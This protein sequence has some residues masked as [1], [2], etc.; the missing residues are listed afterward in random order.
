MNLEGILTEITGAADLAALDALRVST[1]GK[2]GS[3]SE[4]LKTLGGMS[5]EERKTQGAVIN[6]A[7]EAVTSAIK[8]RQAVLEE[9]AMAVQLQREAAD[10][11]LPVLP[12]PVGVLHPIMET[13]SVIRNYF[14]RQGFALGTGQD[15]EDVAHNF[16][17]LN[18]PPHHPARQMH[19][20][21]YVE[22]QD[23]N[24]EA[25][26]LRTHTSP[27]Q[28][29]YLKNHKP[30]LRML[31]MGRTF[32]A[33]SDQTHTP[34]FHQ[35][36]GL[37]IE[38]GVHLGHLKGILE[39]FLKYFFETPHIRLRFRPSFFPFTEPSVEVDIGCRFVA[40]QV[41]IGEGDGWLEVLGAGMVHPN[42]LR[43]VG[44]DP[45]HTHGFAFGMGIERLS[46][47]KYGMPDLRAF[48]GG[49]SRWL[50]HYGTPYYQGTW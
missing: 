43:G 15:I 17:A 41:V 49:D 26:L 46:M 34:M 13:M 42:V 40:D 45:L 24:G 16:T 39:D 6:A 14:L 21:F 31:A 37:V 50:K 35:A 12:L 4:A 36:E 18:F 11:S 29:R 23:D 7:K 10:L 25:L 3:I 44:L 32:R 22:K 38:P 47:L 48:F 27:I 19:D 28:V 33:D 9:Q 8:E 5:P 2:K 1:L 30:P 20:T